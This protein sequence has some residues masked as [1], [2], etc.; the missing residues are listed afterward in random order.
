MKNNP[1][2]EVT[3]HAKL[4]GLERFPHLVNPDTAEADIK[5]MFFN[6]VYLHDDSE[7]GILFLTVDHSAC[8]VVRD[9]KILTVRKPNKRQSSR[10]SASSRAS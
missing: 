4:R 6:S 2:I 7:R 8:I 5:E 9:R 3:E 10:A 1:K